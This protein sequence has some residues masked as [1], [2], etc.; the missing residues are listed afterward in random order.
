[1]S[2]RL[3]THPN[4]EFLKNQA[5]DLLADRRVSHPAWKLTD[6]QPALA[7][8]YGFDSWPKLKAHVE[9]CDRTASPFAGRWIANAAQSTRHP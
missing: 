3:P 9:S 1:M 6:A 4:L 2:R 8:E 5:K 7:R